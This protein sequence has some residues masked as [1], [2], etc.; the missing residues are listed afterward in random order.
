MR[1][2]SP[3]RGGQSDPAA[4][5]GGQRGT[6]AVLTPETLVPWPERRFAR[7]EVLKGARLDSN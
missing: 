1:L 2:D 4:A 3:F 5:V 6:C 7:L